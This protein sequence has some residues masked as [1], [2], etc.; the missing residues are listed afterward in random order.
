MRHSS[1]ESKATLRSLSDCIDKRCP[2]SCDMHDR[3]HYYKPSHHDS[4]APLCL[5]VRPA[6]LEALVARFTIHT[7]THSS[8]TLVLPPGV[9][10][11]ELLIAAQRN[12]QARFDTDLIDQEL[13]AEW[14]MLP[15]FTEVLHYARKVEVAVLTDSVAA[16]RM[17]EHERLLMNHGYI[18]A[19]RE[20]TAL[21]FAAFWLATGADIFGGVAAQTADRGLLLN[22]DGLVELDLYRS[23]SVA[24]V[25]RTKMT[26]GSLNLN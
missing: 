8:A 5:P 4:T 11:F 3:N 16:R 17:A 26:D 25:R 2:Y 1:S 14:R 9:S 19:P 10:G 15:R 18:L 7:P 13:L 6:E 24:V 21:G 23:R 12:A 22:T 20:D